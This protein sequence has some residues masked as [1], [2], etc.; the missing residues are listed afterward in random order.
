[1]YIER[2]PNRNSRPAILLRE[3][4]RE[5]KKVCKRTLAN[6][7]D[8]PAQK[9]EALRRVLRDEPLAA[10]E[11]AFAIEC[12]WPHGHVEAVL[13]T[14]RRIG[15]D[16]LIGTKRT[17]ERDLVLAMIAERLIAPCSKLATTR[18]WHSTT[19]AQLLEVE[20]ADGSMAET[21]PERYREFLIAPW[22]GET[23]FLELR[24]GERLMAVAV[25]D[26]LP[27]ALSAVYTFFDPG[28]SERAPGTY[29]ILCQIEEARRL[30]LEHLYL[31][32]WIGA[33]PKMSYK[34]R[35]R[36]LEAWTDEGWRRYERG[37]EVPET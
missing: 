11:D 1:M 23:R 37:E 2:I 15:L 5:G 24:L 6:L 27:G 8:W 16:K 10:P 7:S 9:V 32:Y 3:G 31:G 4:W 35:F 13:E 20:D 30:G 34:D 26:R 22:G 18:M 17:R 14:I 21:S 29:A 28:L 33:C 12:S 25:T 36:P 19:L